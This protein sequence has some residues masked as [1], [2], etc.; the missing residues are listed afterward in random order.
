[1]KPKIHLKSGRRAERGSAVLVVLALLAI[2]LV[3][4]AYNVRTLD[5]LRQDVRLVERQQLR[6][7]AACART[8]A[9]PRVE[10]RALPPVTNAPPA[11]TNQLNRR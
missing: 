4:V 7:L 6:R 2:I 10:F 11:V 3:Y 8:N 9:P 1:M 5:L